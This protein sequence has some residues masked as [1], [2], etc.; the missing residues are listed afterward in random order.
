V[1]VWTGTGDHDDW[2]G[3]GEPVTASAAGLGRE[4]RRPV[5]DGTVEALARFRAEQYVVGVAGV[6]RPAT[7]SCSALPEDG[8]RRCTVD[9]DGLRAEVDVNTTMYDIPRLEPTTYDASLLGVRGHVLVH[10]RQAVL[11]ALFSRFGDHGDLRCEHLADRAVF[12]AGGPL[13]PV[14]YGYPP[15]RGIIRMRFLLG[16]EDTLYAK[17][18]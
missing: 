14:C 10:T 12:V 16:P 7:G 15:G 4:E 8:W 13:P 5:L 17:R 9:Y 6:S 11:A 18:Y 1:F 3:R 2:K